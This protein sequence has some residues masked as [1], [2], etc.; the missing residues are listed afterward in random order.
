[1]DVSS[2]NLLYR[3]KRHYSI[4]D[5]DNTHLVFGRKRD[6]TADHEGKVSTV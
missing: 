6:V 4:V 3:A 5:E 2:E 1:M